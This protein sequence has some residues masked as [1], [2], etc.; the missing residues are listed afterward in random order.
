MLSFVRLNKVQAY[1]EKPRLLQAVKL[2][3]F[4]TAETGEICLDYLV[5]VGRGRIR[6]FTGGLGGLL[7]NRS[8][9]LTFQA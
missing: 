7:A 8:Y 6:F 3:D 2:T 1:K 5:G 9:D 4:L